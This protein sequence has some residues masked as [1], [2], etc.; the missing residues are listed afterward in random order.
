[1]SVKTFLIIFSI[2]LI[3]GIVFCQEHTMAKQKDDPATKLAKTVLKKMG[4]EKAWKKSRYIRFDHVLEVDGVEVSR[5]KHLWDKEIGNYR[6]EWSESED[7][8]VIALINL[9]TKVGTVYINGKLV[10]YN[11]SDPYVEIVYNKFLENSYC[12]YLPHKLLTPGYTLDISTP[13]EEDFKT[14]HQILQLTTTDTGLIP[15]ASYNFY[16]QNEEFIIDRCK[17]FFDDGNK[18]DFLWKNWKKFKKLSFSLLRESPDN[19][20]VIK[21][22]NVQVFKYITPEIFDNINLHLP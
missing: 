14:T 11:L 17:V 4:G 6:L 1:M 20:T 5:F 21:F 19:K 3:L 16:V 8:H 10:D 18:A 2:A 22:E 12:L 15:E 13:E 9:L 7:A